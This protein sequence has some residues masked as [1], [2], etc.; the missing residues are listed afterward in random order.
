LAIGA[1]LILVTQGGSHFIAELGVAFVIA[2]LLGLTV[3]WA[4]EINL[5]RDVFRGMPQV[6]LK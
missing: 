3:H 5:V 1:V 2:A 6:L 4:L